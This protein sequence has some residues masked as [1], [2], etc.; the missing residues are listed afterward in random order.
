MRYKKTEGDIDVVTASLPDRT[1][2]IRNQS[3]LKLQSA[4][5][6]VIELCVQIAVNHDI[7]D[8]RVNNGGYKQFTYFRALGLIESMMD[9]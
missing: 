9:E 6:D 1:A 4:I 7:T 8:S 3:H 5:N 2:L